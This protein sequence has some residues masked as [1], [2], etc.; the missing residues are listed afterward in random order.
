MVSQLLPELD[1][2]VSRGAVRKSSG[3]WSHNYT[4]YTGLCGVALTHLRVGLHCRDVRGDHAAATGFIQSAYT[5][6][7]A[8]LAADPH[9]DQVSF[10]CGTPGYLAIACV[11]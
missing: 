4:V 9:S 10:F 2:C 7:S 11:S 5:T 3:K 8:C 1:E 6:A